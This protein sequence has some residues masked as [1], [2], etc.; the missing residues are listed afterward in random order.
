MK[1]EDATHP[2]V[3]PSR[4]LS[5]V[6]RSA[7]QPRSVMEVGPFAILPISDGA[8]MGF[9]LTGDESAF[10]VAL[11]SAPLEGKLVGASSGNGQ[12]SP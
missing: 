10:S 5:H 7:A 6:G 8:S 3:E 11:N 4:S 12:L 9:E 2:A 1:E